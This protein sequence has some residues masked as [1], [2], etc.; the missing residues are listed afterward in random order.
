MNTQRIC[1]NYGLLCSLSERWIERDFMTSGAKLDLQQMLTLI[2]R[3]LVDRPD[4]VVIE[5]VERESGGTFKIWCN[6]T[7]VGRFMGSNGRTVNAIR[8][9]VN[10]SA[11]KWGFGRFDIEIGKAGACSPADAEQSRPEPWPQNAETD[12]DARQQSVGA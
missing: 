11:A 2:V 4:D 3:S 5:L 9:V 6:P 10:A 1:L 7:D 8:V 12:A